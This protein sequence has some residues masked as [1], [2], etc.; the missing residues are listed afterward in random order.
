MFCQITAGFG[1]NV[2]NFPSPETTYRT[3]K[4]SSLH[5][6]LIREIHFTVVDFYWG[7]GAKLALSNFF[8]ISSLFLRR[9]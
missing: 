5:F 1:A 8:V 7:V 2:N 9:N 3:F 4:D 6:N